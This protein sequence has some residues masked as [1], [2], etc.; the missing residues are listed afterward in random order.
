L[1]NKSIPGSINQEYLCRN[2]GIDEAIAC[3][4]FA[5]NT[6]LNIINSTDFDFLFIDLN[7]LD[8]A[9]YTYNFCSDEYFGVIKTIDG[10]LSGTIEALQKVGIYNDTYLIIISD[11]GASY[12]TVSHGDVK[13]NENLFVPNVKQNYQ[14][15]GNI[16][17]KDTS[18]TVIQA[19]GLQKN[20][21]WRA[22]PLL[23][24]FQ[25]N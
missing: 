19:L 9:G 15:K 24:S 3:D 16:K 10:Y 23:G 11:H 8:T 1:G 7:S 12:H 25:S 18:T 13:D 22:N 14:I 17:N 20:S 6:T 5:F 2:D 4:A 21:Y